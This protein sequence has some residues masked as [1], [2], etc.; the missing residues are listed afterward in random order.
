MGSDG[1]TMGFDWTWID[2]G[3]DP[4]WA[5]SLFP[6]HKLMSMPMA[7]GCRHHGC[8]AWFGCGGALSDSRIRGWSSHTRSTCAMPHRY[9]TIYTFNHFHKVFQG[10][11]RVP[12]G[13]IRCSFHVFSI[14]FYG[15]LGSMVK[16]AFFGGNCSRFTAEGHQRRPWVCPRDIKLLH[17]QILEGHKVL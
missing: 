5:T 13:L 15:F 7:L 12:L 6:K 8:S 2:L 16:A 10:F 1:R 11:F 14:F 17:H 3:I 4:W 9:F